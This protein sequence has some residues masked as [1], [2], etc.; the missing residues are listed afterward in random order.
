MMVE[1][2]MDLHAGG[3]LLVVAL[4]HAHHRLAWL[5][6]AQHLGKAKVPFQPEVSLHHLS[7]QGLIAHSA[8]LMKLELLER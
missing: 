8:T 3:L 2:T 7:S 5:V 6:S 1:P 4:L